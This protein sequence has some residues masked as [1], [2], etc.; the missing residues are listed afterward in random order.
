MFWI[1]EAIL[2]ASS[3]CWYLLERD[4]SYRELIRRNLPYQ[5]LQGVVTLWMC[6]IIAYAFWHYGVGSG[7][8]SMAMAISIPSMLRP[9]DFWVS[10][11]ID[12]RKQKARDQKA[13]T[14]ALNDPEIQETLAMLGRSG[15]DLRGLLNRMHIFVPED[16]LA[17]EALRNAEIV[18]WYFSL[19][20]PEKA[21]RNES[22]MLSLWVRYGD[23]PS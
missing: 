16:K 2:L 1:M 21:T 4:R 6:G 23:R 3:A 13:L 20:N 18:Q 10:S 17:Y 14:A 12:A 7:F 22:L 5:T 11:E 15:R 8:L 19:P 9:R